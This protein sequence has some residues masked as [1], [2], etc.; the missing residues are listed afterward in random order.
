MGGGFAAGAFFLV[1]LYFADLFREGYKFSKVSFA[2]NIGVYQ[3][4]E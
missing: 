4:N 2:L 1:G 3:V